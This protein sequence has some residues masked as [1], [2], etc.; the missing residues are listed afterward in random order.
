MS[1]INACV[2]GVW[3]G[4]CVPLDRVRVGVTACLVLWCVQRAVCSVCMCL[5]V[6]VLRARVG[7]CS[8][9]GFGVVVCATCCV[10]CVCGGACWCVCVCVCQGACVC[11]EGTC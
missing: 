6:R 5:S 2:R 11:V 3:C 9:V 4:V 8:S 1:L 10:L 7:A